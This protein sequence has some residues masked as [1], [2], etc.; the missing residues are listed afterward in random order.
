MIIIAPFDGRIGVIKY[1]VGDTIATGDIITSITGIGDEKEFIAHLPS[2]LIDSVTTDTQVKIVDKGNIIEGQ[3]I[4]ISPHV[5]K[6]ADNFTV[7]IE[8]TGTNNLRHGGYNK[9]HF[10]LNPHKGFVI[11]QKA[12]MN[13]NNG[14]FVFTVNN[15]NKVDK[16]YIKSGIRF[17]DNIEILDDV[18]TD[19][20]VVVEGLTKINQGDVVDPLLTN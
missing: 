8:V 7:A 2:D 1:H 10:L 9:I 14:S 20:K 16:K 3:I 15:E 19:T 17:G 4:S 18:S 6:A 11:P 12:V 13:D 5:T